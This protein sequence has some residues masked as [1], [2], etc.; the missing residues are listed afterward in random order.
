[1]TNRM[2]HT[3]GWLAAGCLLVAMSAPALADSRVRVTIPFAFEVG[4]DSLPAGVYVFSGSG[5]VG[6]PVV[7]IYS[8]G[9]NK[10]IALLTLP[11][12]RQ[13]SS[14][15]PRLKFEI[16]AGTYR[17]SEIW[18]PGREAGLV[19]P[20]TKEQ[21]LIA[22]EQSEVKTVALALRIV[23]GLTVKQIARACL[24]SEAAMEQRTTRA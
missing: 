10:T 20:R 1:M 18:A 23:S 6:S 17:L 15:E 21:A 9:A 24:V 5:L 8:V 14:D 16:L 22:K 2:I 12:G 7:H 4:K 13:T 11:A 3:A 19:V